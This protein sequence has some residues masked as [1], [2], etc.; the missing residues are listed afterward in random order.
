[1]DR[2]RRIVNLL[3]CAYTL[4]ITNVVNIYALLVDP[5]YVAVRAGTDCQIVSSN[6]M[7][8]DCNDSSTTY[9]VLLNIN[10]L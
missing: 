8:H 9:A 7:Q 3:S 10:Y 6:R 4:I 2:P 1:V 5:L